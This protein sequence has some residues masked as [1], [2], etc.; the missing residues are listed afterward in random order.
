M[1]IP[2]KA[3]LFL[4][5]GLFGFLSL[6][7]PTHAHANNK[8]ASFV[9]DAD[10]GLILH[11]RHA[12]KILHP[13][14][15]TKMMTMMMLFEAMDARKVSPN[16]RIRMSRHAASMVPSKLNIPA[17]QT[18][19][20]KDAI[21][22]L[23]TKSANDVAVAVA[24]HLGKTESQFAQ[25]MTRRARN[26]GMTRTTFRNASGL[27][28]PKQVSTARDMAKLARYILIRYPHHYH[29]FNTKNFNYKGTNYRNHNK[30]LGTYKG[31]DGFKTGY[32][33][34]AG[35]NLVASAKRNGNRII[36]VVFGGRSGKTRNAHMVELLDKGFG[37]L[38]KVR[39]AAASGV[40][41]P[42]PKPSSVQLA[43]AIAPAGG[44]TSMSSLAADTSRN[45][46]V[47]TAQARPQ[48]FQN[49][50]IGAFSEMIGQ[51][52][53][54]PAV[55]KRLETGLLAVAV[56]KGEY[57]PN[58]N[59]SVVDKGIREA[60]HAVISRMDRSQNQQATQMAPAKM[61]T[62]S[63]APSGRWA[64]QIGAYNSRAHVDYALRKAQGQLPTSLNRAQ[65]TVV[66]LRTANGLLYRARLT[67]YSKSEAQNACKLFK[68]CMTIAP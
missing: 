27:H 62:V 39:I 10:T 14:S 11:Q 29:Y 23:A 3:Q 18:I 38:D 21:Y 58:P 44:F 35:F 13:A 24:E 40:P 8:Y 61:R 33:N 30:L 7:I 53:Y 60:G 67:G 32:I 45:T 68:D 46:R 9:M 26:I 6:I 12:D 25:Q 66:P 52:D 19:R 36:G 48:R 28:H 2:R 37:R 64:I 47:T 49:M 4:L 54:D 17:G 1:M 57:E 31:A 42:E 15:L 65:P 43:S 20:V 34:A 5:L 16:T 50:D 59:F 56:H 51:G 22:A 63:Y 41:I 55:S